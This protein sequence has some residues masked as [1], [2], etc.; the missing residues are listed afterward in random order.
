[1]AQPMPDFV[2]EDGTVREFT[3]EDLERLTETLDRVFARMYAAGSVLVTTNAD[4]VA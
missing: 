2:M 1:M 4:E 3:A